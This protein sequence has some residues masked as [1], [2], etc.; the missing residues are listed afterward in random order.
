MPS[1]KNYVRDYSQ[2][3]KTAKGRGE[4]V[5]NKLRKRDRRLMVKKGLVRAGDGRDVDHVHA[6]DMGGTGGM[7]STENLRVVSKHDNRSFPRDRK[8]SM[9]SNT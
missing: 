9:K 8:G 6:L 1:S 3:Y 2:E 4:Q 7:G 5:D